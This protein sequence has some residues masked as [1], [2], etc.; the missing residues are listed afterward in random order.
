MA[1]RRDRPARLRRRFAAPGA[2]RHPPPRDGGRPPTPGRDPPAPRA[3]QL[4][5]DPDQETFSGRI[6]ITARVNEP[7]SLVWLNGENLTVSR[8]SAVV[9]SETWPLEV[10]PLQE[11]KPFVGLRAPRELAPGP[12]VLDLE[13]SGQIDPVETLGVFRQKDGERW[14]A[15]TQFEPLGARRAFPCF[16]EPDSKVPWQLTLEVPESLVAVANTPST[17]EESTGRGTKRV[18][19]AQTKPLPSYLVAFGV[20]PFDVVEGGATRNGTPL[21]VVV[22]NGRGGDVQYTVDTTPKV[23]ALLEDYFGIPY[24]FEKLDSLAIPLTVNFGAMENPGLITYREPLLPLLAAKPADFTIGY[25]RRYASTGT[26]ELAHQ[27]FGNLVTMRF[28]DDLWLNEA[29]ATWMAGRIIDQ[30]KPEWG[31]GVG[32]ITRRSGAI[33][34]DSLASARRIRQAIQT[35]DDVESA[36]DG[37]TYQKGA[38]VIRMFERWVGPEAF[39]EG[40]RAYLAKHAGGNAT[41]A[42]FLAAVGAAA[43]RD[44]ATP[45]NTFLDQVG[46]P[47]VSFELR[48]EANQS[49]R[50]LLSQERYL[51]LGSR[52][53]SAPC[54]PPR[55]PSSSS[56]RRRP[57]P[58]GC[59]PTTARSATTAPPSRSPCSRS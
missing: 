56:S 42:D 44:V 51:P 47:L 55:P 19:F 22:S 38:S 53:A 33:G 29:F 27:W 2:R 7:T 54:W 32:D 28:W 1:V 30:Y 41:S 43:G 24:P 13:Y 10:L 23:L 35:E 40:V 18:S 34:Q 17:S 9:G 26:H 37:I 46:T 16:D 11:G 36:F 21:R 15:F 14:Y 59:C 6:E 8:A 31:A 57:A 49:P 3:A 45:F 39:R 4:V 48:C 52:P 50:L 58:S 20:G 12:V 25:Q 5:L